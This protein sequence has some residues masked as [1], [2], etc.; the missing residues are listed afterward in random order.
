MCYCLFRT[1]TNVD[2]LVRAPS[3]MVWHG[4]C[5]LLQSTGRPNRLK[6]LSQPW[7]E[8]LITKTHWWTE[9]KQKFYLRPWVS[10]TVEIKLC[11]Y[12]LIIIL[13][14]LMTCCEVFTW[15]HIKGFSKARLFCRK[16]STIET[17]SS[18]QLVCIMWPTSRTGVNFLSLKKW[19]ALVHLLAQT[20]T[21]CR[22]LLGCHHSSAHLTV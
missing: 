9:P 16:G 20:I 21:R 2:V 22:R 10:A 17:K 12:Y 3:G 4:V 15:V 14:V 13:N 8:G 5:R 6:G 1:S 7:Q 11:D 19:V 18:V